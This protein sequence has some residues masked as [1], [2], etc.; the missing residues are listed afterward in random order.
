MKKNLIYLGISADSLHP[1]HINLIEKSKTYG[2]LIIG[3]ISD[4]A[5]AKNKKKKSFYNY[6]QRKKIVSNLKGV[7][8]IV[9]Q[10]DWD[11][12]VNLR[13]IKPQ[14]FIHGDDWKF[15]PD[16]KI[17]ENVINVLKSYGGELIEVPYLKGVES[18]SIN[19]SNNSLLT[20]TPE[21]RLSS[22]KKLLYEKKFLRLIETHSP[23]SAII[24]EKTKII[25]KTRIIS[26][27]D[28]FWSSSLTDSTCNGKPDTES[29]DMSSRIQNIDKIFDVTFKPLIIDIDTG[30]K[31]EHI[32]MKINS[33]E[34]LGVSAAIM[35]DKKGIK[36]NSLHKNTSNQ[37]QEEIGLFSEKLK[38][39]KKN[40]T[41][42]DF[43]II[44]RI[45]SLILGKSLKDAY[46]RASAYVEAGA[47]GIM[48]HSK[49]TT[50]NEIFNF[51][52][53][54]KK[55][56]Q[57]IPLVCVPSTY[58]KVRE[59]KLR[60]NGINIVIYANHM[61][62]ASYNAMKNVAFDILKNKRSKESDKNLTSISE[63]INLIP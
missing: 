35:E 4:D 57:D 61:L 6:Q 26:E 42:E 16:R 27:F 1:A 31:L 62:R 58:N 13:R 52:K 49:S 21:I 44:A 38:K 3:L 32:S 23:I 56:Y 24:A 45:E 46:K 36:R 25:K 2:K 14:Y 15:G 30:G 50:P 29:L 28:G 37:E 39:I 20:T 53:I 34:R 54:F 60:S 18:H 55:K 22:L 40:Q 10:K 48:I 19:A 41:T 5:I 8:E 43:M 12:S 17:R 33:L 63:I 47:D 11:Y 51:A 9:E 7:E 59:E